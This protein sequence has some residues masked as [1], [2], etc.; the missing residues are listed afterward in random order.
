[1]RILYLV[2]QLDRCSLTDSSL[3]TF[4]LA[5]DRAAQGHTVHVLC[6]HPLEAWQEP[7]DPAGV[8][9][10]RPTPDQFESE[11]GEA[12]R[13][14]PDVVHV[15][16]RGPLG[17]RVIEILRELPVLLD[18]HDFWPICPNDDL[19][20][21]PDST[22]CA[23]HHPHER[24]GPCAGLS[25]LRAMS[26]R[27][28]LADAARI[29]IS[30]SPGQCLRLQTGLGRPIQYVGY[31]VDTARYR[32]RPAPPLVDE[33]LRLL[34]LAPRPRVLCLGPPTHTRGAERLLDLLVACR[35]RLPEVEFV[36]AGRDPANPD[37]HHMLLKEAHEMGL[38]D[39]VRV[40]TAVPES[41]LP[42]L[43]AASDV[44]A[45]PWSGSEHGGLAILHAMSTG[46]PVV[47]SPSGA[48]AE[49]VRHGS[50]GLLIPPDQVTPF[51]QALCGLL[52]DQVAR[53]VL[54]ESARLRV[55]EMHGRERTF[56]A[57]ERLY[58]RLGGQPQQRLTA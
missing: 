37:W 51:A 45:A 44:A 36:M 7:R 31:G 56:V 15:G 35:A 11:L 19:L 6:L 40:M 32:S 29:V 49:L 2:D 33:G 21:R 13:I 4:D 16:T 43:C 24:C 20:Q 5:A 25:R 26:E 52:T 38:S 28:E 22:P 17:A 14:E 55:V 9:V 42:A 46:L 8:T 12:L 3:W 54:G 1:M 39:H 27:R 53:I 10:S 30:H 34:T 48:V 41:D 57:L 18:V 58:E 23:L 47:G 50:D